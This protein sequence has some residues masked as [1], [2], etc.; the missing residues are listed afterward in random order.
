M[1]TAFVMNNASIYVRFCNGLCIMIHDSAVIVTSICVASSGQN[2][3]LVM[4]GALWHIM[5]LGESSRSNTK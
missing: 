5:I 2:R 4:I 3:S 1:M